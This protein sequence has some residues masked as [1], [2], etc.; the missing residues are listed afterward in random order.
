MR[1]RVD[2]GQRLVDAVHVAEPG[3]AAVAR[4][5]HVVQQRRLGRHRHVA[6]VGVPVL[7][8]QRRL[9]GRAVGHQRA[10]HGRDFGHLV[11]AL[12][13]QQLRPRLA[14]RRREIAHQRRCHR[15]ARHHDQ[16]MLAERLVE[17]PRRRRAWSRPASRCLRCGRRA[18][19]RAERLSCARSLA[20]EQGGNQFRHP[21]ARRLHHRL[22]LLPGRQRLHEGVGP[23]APGEE[24]GVGPGEPRGWSSGSAA[25][26]DRAAPGSPSPAAC[27]AITEPSARP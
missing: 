23:V 15:L 10:H 1:L 7:R 17:R 2:S 20:R 14:E 6:V 22:R 8:A 26:C 13:A 12:V 18:A 16:Q 3:A 19:R 27:P 24:L 9:V 4:G 25:G 21:G 11:V 5:L